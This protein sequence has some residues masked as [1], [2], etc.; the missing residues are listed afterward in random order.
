MPCPSLTFL[1][2]SI[3]CMQ[4]VKMKIKEMKPPYAY[5]EQARV[6]NAMRS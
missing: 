2:V 3:F 6:V 1:L 4:E 5:Y